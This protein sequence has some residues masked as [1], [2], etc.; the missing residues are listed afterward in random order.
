MTDRERA[1]A[2]GLPDGCRVRERAKILAPEKLVLGKDVWIGEGAMLDAQGGLW[3]GDNT[4]IGLNAL[5]WSHTSHLQ[6]ILGKTGSAN[7]DGIQ[8][9]ETRIGRNCFIGS[10]AVI[11]PGLTIGN[12]AIISPLTFVERDVAD[13]EVVNGQAQLRELVDRVAK[14]E[15]LLAE[16]G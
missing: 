4:Q 16:K 14:L 15:R 1:R 10:M 12:R 9:K 5:I 13:G 2:L 6:A 11:A 3:I 7:K 8:Y